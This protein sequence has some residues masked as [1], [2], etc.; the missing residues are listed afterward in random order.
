VLKF[1]YIKILPIFRMSRMTV[2]NLI[3]DLD[4]KIWNLFEIVWKKTIPSILVNDD[5][6]D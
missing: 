5:L 1:E 3:C 2:T 6:W 4:F